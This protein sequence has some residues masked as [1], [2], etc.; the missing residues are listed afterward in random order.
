MSTASIIL[1]LGG[2]YF[3][4]LLL[5]RVFAKTGVP[6]VLFLILLG[7]LVGPVLHLVE[8]SDFGRVGEVATTLALTVILFESGTTLNLK[9][10]FS[11]AFSTSVLTLSTFFTTVLIVCLGAKSL[12]GM[13]WGQSL[14]TGAIL[15][16]TSS[17]VVIP[18]VKSLKLAEKAATILVMESALTDVLCI[19]VTVALVDSLISGQVDM[20]LVGQSIVL[21]LG[22][23]GALGVLAGLVWLFPCKELRKLPDSQ[24]MTLAFCL[25]VFGVAEMVGVSGAIAVLLFGLTLAQAGEVIKHR[26]VPALTEAEYGIYREMVFVMKVFFF[27]YLGISF[28]VPSLDLAVAA[29][30]VVLLIYLARIPLTRFLVKGV[31]LNDTKSI[32]ILVPKGLAAAVLATL[33]LQRG[34]AEADVIQ[35]FVFSSVIVSIFLTAALVPLIRVP[36]V[37][38]W[39]AWALGAALERPTTRGGKV[40]S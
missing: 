35:G 21:S 4:A 39:Y 5:G 9:T 1:V 11:S 29:T 3:L 18:L 24:F 25:V 40:K 22:V 27:V 26:E 20:V 19:V 23:A 30:L 28:Q 37:A 10:L 33:P 17:A 6:D 8:P 12:V 34:I 32:S 36:P 38:D 14:L 15:G 16:G 31:S 7:I 2:L 13:P